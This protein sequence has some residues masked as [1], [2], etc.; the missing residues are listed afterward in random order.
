MTSMRDAKIVHTEVLGNKY[1]R[2]LKEDLLLPGGAQFDWIYLD[3][4]KSL[5]IIA[6][7]QRK[8]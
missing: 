1:K 4:P 5:A 6:L 3:K 7:H 8:N 2:I